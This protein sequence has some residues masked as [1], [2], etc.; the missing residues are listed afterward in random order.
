MKFQSTFSVCA[1]TATLIGSALV[2]SPV[3]AGDDI[4][5]LK[6]ASRTS[7]SSHDS[8]EGNKLYQDEPESTRSHESDKRADFY[9]ESKSGSMKSIVLR[10][11]RDDD[12]MDEHLDDDDDSHD[13]HDDQHERRA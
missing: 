9:A 6:A 13:S 2:F 10:S 12:D 1:A 4:H 3:H 11:K 7:I 8:S 5:E